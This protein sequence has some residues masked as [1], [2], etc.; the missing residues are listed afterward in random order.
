MWGEGC[1]D[2]CWNWAETRN[3][4]IELWGQLKF[5]EFSP[6]HTVKLLSTGWVVGQGQSYLP[7]FLL[8]MSTNGFVVTLKNIRTSM[9]EFLFHTQYSHSTNCLKFLKGNT[10]AKFSKEL[11]FG[12]SSTTSYIFIKCLISEIVCSRPLFWY[13]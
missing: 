3:V 10:K 1:Q 7:Y 11:I 9:K 4:E 13:P 8:L 6:F 12:F 2:L 5:V